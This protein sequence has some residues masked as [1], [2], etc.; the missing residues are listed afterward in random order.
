MVSALTTLVVSQQFRFIDAAIEA[1]VKR[2]VASEYGLN[3]A[4][5]EARGLSSVFDDKG[6]V[7]EYLREKEKDGLTWSSVSCGMWIGW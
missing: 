5:P 6:R 3:N 4:N 1:G 2:F 7:Q